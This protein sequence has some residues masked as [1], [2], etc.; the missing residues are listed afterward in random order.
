MGTSKYQVIAT[1]YE[2]ARLALSNSHKAIK[3]TG[4]ELITELT[5]RLNIR[6]IARRVRRS[7]QYINDIYHGHGWLDPETYLDMV[8]LYESGEYDAIYQQKQ[9]SLHH[10]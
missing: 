6:Q 10:E 5:L 2:D 4:R 7:P 9:A 3:E 1:E 8:K